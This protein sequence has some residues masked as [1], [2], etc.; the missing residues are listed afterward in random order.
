MG[1]GELAG[2]GKRTLNGLVGRMGFQI[3]RSQT[4]ERLVHPVEAVEPR[5][6]VADGQKLLP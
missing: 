6:G 4:L 1:A 2:L 5:A 3:V